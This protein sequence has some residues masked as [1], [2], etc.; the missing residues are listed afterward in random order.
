MEGGDKDGGAD[1]AGRGRPGFCM[2]LI[3]LVKAASKDGA[4]G[5]ETQGPGSLTWDPPLALEKSVKV[6]FSG[7]GKSFSC[8]KL[9][10]TSS[11]KPSGV[12]NE[13][14]WHRDAASKRI[15]LGLSMFIWVFPP[16][17]H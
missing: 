16:P 5:L 7:L 17:S 10:L 13:H 6:T 15:Q 12:A 11:A 1:G 2:E 4:Q 3:S 14:N 8:L 9:H